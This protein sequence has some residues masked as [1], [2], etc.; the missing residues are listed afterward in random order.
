M[1]YVGELS[2]ILTAC[3]W[4][5][6]SFLFAFA[7]AKVGSVQVNINR[8]VLA[9]IILFLVVEI[10]GIDYNLS[11][12]QILFLI[13]SGITGLVFG[14]SFLFKAYQQIGARL[15]MVL[16]SLVPA[17]SALLAWIFLN[18]IITPIGIVGMFITIFG[19]LLVVTDKS[20]SSSVQGHFD[21]IGI[22]SGFLGA[23][24]QA[25]GLVLAKV[26][27]AEG[28]VNGF[29]ASFT[30]LSS[31][32]LLILVIG[33]LF[34]R[35]KNPIKIYKN[36]IPALKA[37]IAATVLAP[38]L[39]VTLSLVAIEFTKVG[40]ASTLMALVPIIMLPISKYYYRENLSTQAIS[41]AFIAVAGVVILFLR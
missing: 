9:A 24:G 14:D 30:R 11:S 33:I 15:G 35:Y 32:G 4:S 12:R 13:L 28:Y 10:G 26:A 2:A 3:L 8:I 39:G 5:V 34:K 7:A 17:I 37:T 29:V 41:G 6:T 16:M 19:V 23:A 27:F 21:K 36:E 31:A 38:V 25:G 22:L 40:I 1:P 20:H 18:E